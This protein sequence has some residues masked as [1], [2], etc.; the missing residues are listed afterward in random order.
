MYLGW[1]KTVSSYVIIN[2]IPFYSH[3]YLGLND[4]LYGHPILKRYLHN[5]LR[6]IGR[7][8]WE[9]RT[10]LNAD[11]ENKL[12]GLVNHLMLL[13]LDY[14]ILPKTVKFLCLKVI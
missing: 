10:V 6:W 12:Y 7:G 2:S 8:D 1:P 14:I 11:L 13:S 9:A 5:V 4:K 3:E